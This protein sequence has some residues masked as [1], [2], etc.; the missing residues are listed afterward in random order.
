MYILK[1]HY[2][3]FRFEFAIFPKTVFCFVKLT[4][5]RYYFHGSFP[6]TVEDRRHEDV[7]A[8]N[9]DDE[10]LPSYTIVSGLPTYEEALEQ[11]KKVK[12][13]VAKPPAV[14]TA[15][16]APEVARP[17][18]DT[19]PQMQTLSVMELFQ[20]YKNTST[21]HPEVEAKG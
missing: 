1:L 2:A 15:A 7:E 12:A 17:H 18:A 11:L 21:Q 20:I 6:L 9:G 8:S 13:V 4:G 3:M 16:K 19:P 10:S 5:A 14:S